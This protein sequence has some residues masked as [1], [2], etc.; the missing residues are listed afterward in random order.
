[1]V[2]QEDLS[3]LAEVLQAQVD[4]PTRAVVNSESAFVYNKLRKLN[5]IKLADQ[6]WGW[7]CS[8]PRTSLFFDDKIDKLQSDLDKIDKKITMPTWGTYGT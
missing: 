8:Y 4:K 5:H 1:M 2:S 3:I 7:V 6:Y